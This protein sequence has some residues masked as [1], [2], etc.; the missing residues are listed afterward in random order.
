MN[1]ITILFICG[2]YN[3]LFAIFHILFWKIF[4]WKKDLKRISIA[5]RAIMQ[6]LNIRVIYIFL[7]MAFIYLFYPEQLIETRIGYILFIGF[8]VFWIGRTIEQFIFLKVRSKMV[9]VLTIVF[10]IGIIIHL[11]PLI[12]E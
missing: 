8:T 11:T 3:L 7:L 9:N 1:K 6:I 10:I 4:N 12:M 5:S 2:I